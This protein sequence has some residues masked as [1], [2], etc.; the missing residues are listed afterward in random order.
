MLS[1]TNTD[2]DIFFVPNG[3]GEIVV[4]DNIFLTFGDSKDAKNNI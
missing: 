3:S 2:G 1:S 4:G